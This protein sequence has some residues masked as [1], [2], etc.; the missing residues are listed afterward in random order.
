MKYV[1]R[2]DRVEQ[3]RLYAGQDVSGRSRFRSAI[4]TLHTYHEDADG[5]PVVFTD[6]EKARARA[7][8]LG[9]G[10]K[11]RKQTAKRAVGRVFK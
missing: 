11:V 6:I 5:K 2:H 9:P 1:L 3:V 4:R 7:R 10:W 8:E